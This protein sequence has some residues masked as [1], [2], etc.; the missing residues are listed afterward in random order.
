MRSRRL[1]KIHL[2]YQNIVY[3]KRS[4]FSPHFSN[5][6]LSVAVLFTSKNLRKLPGPFVSPATAW[7]Q[8]NELAAIQ[9]TNTS[10][11]GD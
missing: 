8:L 2:H 9:H 1:E 4:N 7:D 11:G 3:N 6:L 10:H 5:P